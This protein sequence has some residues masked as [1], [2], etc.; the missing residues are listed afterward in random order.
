MNY[1]NI[2]ELYEYIIIYIIHSFFLSFPQNRE[3]GKR[4]YIAAYS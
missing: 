3:K 1:M 2:Y 4:N